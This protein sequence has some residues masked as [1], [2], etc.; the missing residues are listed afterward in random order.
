MEHY[1]VIEKSL[2]YIENNIEKSLS[3][4]SVANQFNLS[5]YYFHRLFS[6]MMGCSL[7]QYLLSRRLNAAVKLIQNENLSLTDIAYQ[8]NFGTP[9]SFTRAF[10]REYGLAPSLLREKSETIPQAPIPTVVQRPIKNINGA[11]VTDFTLTEFKAV[12]L[13]GIAFEVDIATQDY[14]QT[15]NL[16]QLDST[17]CL[18]FHMI[19][20]LINPIILP[21]MCRKSFVLSSTTLVIYST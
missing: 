13:C 5:K 2:I 4:D 19:Y 10:K 18:G 8:L 12:R 16:I 1:E 20:K 14:K 21:M 7:N 9:S 11:I 3:L 15:V 17:F 6:A